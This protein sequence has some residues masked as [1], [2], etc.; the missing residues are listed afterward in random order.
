MS[1]A[2]LASSIGFG[3]TKCSG[4][5]SSKVWSKTISLRLFDD[6]LDSSIDS[7][8]FSS[9]FR[10]LRPWPTSL[11]WLLNLWIL[12]CTKCCYILF[13]VP[14]I[15][16]LIFDILSGRANGPVPHWLRIYSLGCDKGTPVLN[17]LWCPSHKSV[18]SL[19][20]HLWWW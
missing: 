15:N 14:Y 11:L 18:W 3:G 19:I 13:C 20:T 12:Y 7:S 4:L 1:C 2:Y 16:N 9:K 17:N 8:D 10:I 5:N 6:S